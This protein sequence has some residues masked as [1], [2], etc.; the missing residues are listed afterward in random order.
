MKNFVVLPTEDE[1]IRVA[2][3][4]IVQTTLPFCE[5]EQKESG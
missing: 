1:E 2:V 3:R 4:R 5:S